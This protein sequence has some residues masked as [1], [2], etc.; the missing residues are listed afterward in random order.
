MRVRYNDEDGYD[1]DQEVKIDDML[2]ELG[3][4]TLGERALSSILLQTRYSKMM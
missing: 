4:K 3:E 1:I 2:K